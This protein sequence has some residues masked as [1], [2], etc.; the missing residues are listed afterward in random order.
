MT[1][2]RIL[3]VAFLISA[4]FSAAAEETKSPRDIW[5]LAANAAVTGDYDAAI[6]R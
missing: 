2:R 4:A 5:S 3:A 6:I 1:V